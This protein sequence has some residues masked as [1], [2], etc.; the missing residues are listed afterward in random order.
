MGNRPASSP[1]CLRTRCS[2]V[3]SPMCRS[4]SA[5]QAP[6]CSISASR[7][8]RV[9]IDGLPTRIPPAFIG[10]NGSNGIAF[11]FTVIPARSRAFSAPAHLPPPV[12][13]TRGTKP[14]SPPQSTPPSPQSCA[15]A[16][17]PAF[18]ETSAGRSPSHKPHDTAPCPPAARAASCAWLSTL[19]PHAAPVKDAPPPPPIPR[20]VPCPQKTARPPPLPLSRCA[21]N[22][23]P[24]NTRSL[25]QQSSAAC[26]HAPASRF[27]RNRSARLP[28]AHH[29]PQTCTSDRK[30]LVD[31]H[32]SNARHAPNSCPAPYRLASAW[33]CTPQRSLTSPNAPAHWHAPPQTIPSP[34]QLPVAPLYRHTRSR[35]NTASPD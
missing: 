26:A 28:A 10:G 15:P 25:P 11:L 27:R 7:I 21:Q 32:A 9:V 22:R 13:D 31:A 20:C 17:R 12:S 29:K 14:P 4:T 33:P 23:L 2:A 18:P 6:I 5:I 8:P 30:N 3:A 19:Y 16:A 34:D 1:T 24:A 35:R